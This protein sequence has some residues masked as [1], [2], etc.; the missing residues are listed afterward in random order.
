MVPLKLWNCNP[1]IIRGELLDLAQKARSI[2]ESSMVRFG[3]LTPAL[4]QRLRIKI[5]FPSLK[6]WMPQ[7][8]TK[9]YRISALVIVKVN[10]NLQNS[11]TKMMCSGRP[12]GPKT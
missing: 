5:R 9:V 2:K 8:L 1:H 10:S 3:D 11:P 6:T 4:A 7:I 12:L